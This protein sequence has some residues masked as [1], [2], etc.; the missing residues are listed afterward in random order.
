MKWPG[1]LQH[2]LLS[3]QSAAKLGISHSFMSELFI[4]C[5]WL[6]IV[7]CLSISWNCKKSF[8]LVSNYIGKEGDL[9][10]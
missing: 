4:N 7:A 1:R 10:A 3:E 9:I 6:I 2:S 5:E 8:F